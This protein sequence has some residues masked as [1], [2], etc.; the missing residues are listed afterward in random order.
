M[1]RL[2]LKPRLSPRR[3]LLRFVLEPQRNL[4]REPPRLVEPRRDLS[5]EPPRLVH[6]R[7]LSLG[8]ALPRLVEPRLSLSP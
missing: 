7:L 2:V 6:E 8:C 1:P 3:A 5:R 4:S